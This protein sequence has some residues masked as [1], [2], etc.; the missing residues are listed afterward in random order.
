MESTSLTGAYEFVIRPGI[1]TVMN[2]KADIFIRKPIRKLGIAP[3]SSMFFFGKNSPNRSE[4]D[5][6]LEV[7]D[8]DGLLIKDKSGELTWHPL[9]NPQ[10]LLINSFGGGQP[11]GFGLMQRDTNFDHYQDLEARYDLRPSAWVEP[12]GDW[13]PG[14]IELLQIPSG[15]EYNDNIS[16]YWVPEKSFKSGDSLSFAYTLS[17][18]SAKN[19]RVGIA[20]VEST[21]IVKKQDSV[22]FM[23]DFFPDSKQN[24]LYKKDLTVDIREFNGYKIAETQI[25]KNTVT[26]G[27][28][29]LIRVRF[30]KESFLQ[31]ILPKELPAVELRAFIKDKTAAVTETWSYTYLP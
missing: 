16:S 22:T 28:R 20:T 27:L 3:L 2:V 4:S 17:W 10:R 14:H 21:R 26:K 31:E 23:V 18:L 8:S 15:N 1:E 12:E 25:I 13:G 11:A 30:D 6:R 5:F 7:H 24:L 29:L 19:K 9:I